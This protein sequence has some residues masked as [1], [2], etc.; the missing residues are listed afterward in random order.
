MQT[1]IRTNV[2]VELGIAGFLIL[3]PL[4]FAALP[5]KTKFAGRA[6]AISLGVSV[7]LLILTAFLFDML[8]G[9]SAQWSFSLGMWAL[10]LIPCLAIRLRHQSRF[11][12]VALGVITVFIAVQHILDLSSVKPYRRFFAA[13]EPGMTETEVTRKLDQQFPADGTF[14]VPVRY[15][16]RTNEISFALDPNESAWNAEAIVIHLDNGRVVTKE[17]WRD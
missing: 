15:D 7:V 4:L 8:L 5:L 12:L 2:I 6:A 14:P 17:Y 16:F 3:L 1:S 11:A 9:L 10:G 13:I